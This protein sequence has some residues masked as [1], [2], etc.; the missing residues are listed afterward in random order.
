MQTKSE[1]HVALIGDFI[2]IG[3]GEASPG[4]SR[5]VVISF[6]A[7]LKPRHEVFNGGACFEILK[8][9]SDRH[10]RATEDPCSAYVFG[11]AFDGGAL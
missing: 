5:T 6:A 9:G 10:A 11:R 7:Q 8:Y 3:S 2:V 4:K 1:A